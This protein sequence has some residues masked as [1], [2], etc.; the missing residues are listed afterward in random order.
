MQNMVS[1]SIHTLADSVSLLQNQPLLSSQGAGYSLYEL[2]NLGV[3]LAILIAGGLSVVYIFIGGISF[4]LSAGK[5]DKIKEAVHTIRYAI[6]GLVITV[7]AVTII[8]VI[9]SVFDFNLVSYLS[10]DKILEL[11]D[12]ITSSVRDTGSPTPGRL[13]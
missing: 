4:I 13:Q 9:G 3:A 8:A 5:E 2:A 11:I 6:I 12:K 10:W 1:S 7:M